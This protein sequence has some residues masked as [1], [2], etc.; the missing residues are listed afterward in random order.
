MKF[1]RWLFHETNEA[2]LTLSW[3]DFLG[4]CFEVGGELSSSPQSKTC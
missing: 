4:L 1:I 3:V 2:S